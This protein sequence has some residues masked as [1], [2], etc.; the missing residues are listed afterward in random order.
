MP[1]KISSRKAKAR[2]LQNLVRDT[3]RYIFKNQ[4]EEDD[5]IARQMGGSGTDMVLSP[6]S[7]KLI[8]FDVECKAQE[9]LNVPASLRQ[10]SNNTVEGRIPLLIFTKNKGK[11]YAALEFEHLIRLLYNQDLQ[12]IIVEVAQEK[13]AALTEK[14][15][16]SGT[17]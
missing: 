5:I 7:K 15:E 16:E 9:N 12:K 14:L 1:T 17:L 6:A 2:R 10:A 13:A 4:L 11:V 8:P 3:F